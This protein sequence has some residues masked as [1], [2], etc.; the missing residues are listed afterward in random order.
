MAADVVANVDASAA[1]SATKIVRRLRGI[2]RA[3]AKRVR[4]PAEIDPQ[5]VR[6]VDK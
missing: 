3:L 1:A 2:A 6:G 5:E 4:C